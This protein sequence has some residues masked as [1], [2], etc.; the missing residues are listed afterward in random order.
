MISL[1]GYIMTALTIVGAVF[2][3]GRQSGYKKAASQVDAAT[4]VADESRAEAAASKAEAAA[5][6]DAVNS[7]EKMR[8]IIERTDDADVTQQLHDRWQR[9]G[10]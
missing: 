5:Q 10:D 4:A 3:V 6:I 8:E 1:F 7:A 2:F 9:P